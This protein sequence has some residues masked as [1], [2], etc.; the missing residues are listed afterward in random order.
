MMQMARGFEKIT[1]DVGWEFYMPILTYDDIEEFGLGTMDL[2]EFVFGTPLCIGFIPP[3][4]ARCR[5]ASC[6]RSIE[7]FIWRIE[8]MLRMIEWYL[9]LEKKNKILKEF[10]GKI[11]LIIWKIGWWIT[12]DPP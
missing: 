3:R 9:I 12:V 11:R 7:K 1:D 4:V 8:N 6:M 2:A 10:I 5:H